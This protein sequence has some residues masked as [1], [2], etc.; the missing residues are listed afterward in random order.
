[1]TKTKTNNVAT[2]DKNFSGFMILNYS[3]A[4]AYVL[5]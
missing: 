3:N 1:M 5:L 4:Y 2:M